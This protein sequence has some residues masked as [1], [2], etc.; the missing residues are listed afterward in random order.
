[1]NCNFQG[2]NIMDMDGNGIL[3]SM[4]V[5]NMRLEDLRKAADQVSP[6]LSFPPATK[7][8]MA[9]RSLAVFDWIEVG[10]LT[11]TPRSKGWPRIS[12]TQIV[13]IY[14]LEPEFWITS[15][16]AY[17]STLAK[18]GEYSVKNLFC[19]QVRAVGWV[20]EPEVWLHSGTTFSNF[21][22]GRTNHIAIK[23]SAVMHAAQDIS[24]TH[25]IARRIFDIHIVFG[26][27]TKSYKQCVGGGFL[28]YV[29]DA[30]NCW[31]LVHQF[32]R[33]NR[34]CQCVRYLS[35]FTHATARH[36]DAV[37]PTTHDLRCWSAK[38][39]LLHYP[40]ASIFCYK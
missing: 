29:C 2:F 17:V 1:M 9:T 36:I 18:N 35:F 7:L 31:G 3:T 20:I 14:T 10:T 40:S 12:V 34:E 37:E 30:Y 28:V 19:L 33:I 6:G 23:I 24:K 15:V 32:P 16:K 13:R 27:Q 5:N 25:T 21:L 4:E 11:E 8:Y 38:S 26:S 39:S 22:H